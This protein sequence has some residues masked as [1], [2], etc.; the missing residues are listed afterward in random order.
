M[1]IWIAFI[2]FVLAMLALDLGVF[3]RKAHVVSIREAFAWTGFWI[4]LA[5]AFNIGI[6]YFYEHNWLGIGTEIGHELSGKQAALQFFTGYVVEKSLS[7]DNIFVIALIFAYFKIPGMHQHRVLFYGILGALV[8]RGV[9]IALGAVLIRSFDWIVYVFGALLLLTAVKMLVQ[10]HD[11]LQPDKN[12][13]VKLARKVYPVSSEL[14]GNRFFT[15]TDGRRAV[16]PLFLTLVMIESSDV[17]FAVDSIPAIFAITH[18]V[19]L[20][21]TSNVFAVLGLRSLYFALAATID[22]F[23]YLKMGLVFLLAYVGVKMILSH[24][25]PIPTL[26]S[27]SIIGGILGVSIVASIVAANRDTAKLLSPLKDD[28]EELA[29]LTYD[30]AKRIVIV[31]FGT[32]LLMI[33]ILML[34]LPGPGMLAIIGGLAVLA[35]Q[36]FWARRMLRRSKSEVDQIGRKIGIELPEDDA[37]ESRCKKNK[38]DKTPDDWKE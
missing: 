31:L 1:T 6:Y 19:F 33:G 38:D 10:R 28:L 14:D 7:L 8:M 5:L 4:A 29:T 30:R 35:T 13:L 34:I 15:H 37:A 36:L 18:D 20:I 9:M 2:G 16:T 25:H 3:N 24:H 17:L 23:R 32:T 12:P 22:K 21:F 27:L 26:V 11:N